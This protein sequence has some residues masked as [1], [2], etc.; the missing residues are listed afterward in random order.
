MPIF[1]AYITSSTQ[2]CGISQVS[3]CARSIL[4][5]IDAALTSLQKNAPQLR[6]N[7]GRETY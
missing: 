6:R 1:G 2:V 5:Y 7:L 3:N 4:A